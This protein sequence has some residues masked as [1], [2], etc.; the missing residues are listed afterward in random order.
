MSE[1]TFAPR[2]AA[3]DN[4]ATR[5]RRSPLARS[6]H[7]WAGSVRVVSMLLVAELAGC[8]LPPSLSVDNSDAGVNSPPS[9]LAV[10]SDQQEF[11][12][13]STL[14]FEI[15]TSST[16]DLTLLDTDID[17]TLYSRVFVDY[18]IPMPPNPQPPR[19]SCTP[20]A[21]GVAAQRSS[22]CDLHGLC[23][24]TDLGKTHVMSVVVFDRQVLDTGTPTY[25]AMPPGGLSTSRTFFLICQQAS[26]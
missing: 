9:I 16:L 15:N 24:G 23:V 4:P 1:P 6:L 7:A 13:Y 25:Q 5:N 18:D 8:V 26:P 14:T 17:D 3:H 22:T 21:G 2:P 12:E 11:P 20:A 19:S 10:R